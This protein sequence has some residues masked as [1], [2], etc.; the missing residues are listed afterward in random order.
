MSNPIIYR[1]EVALRDVLAERERQD[2]KW[3]E[4]NHDFG[5]FLA[6]LQEEVGEAS[7][8][9]LKSR[10]PSDRDVS[11]EEHLVRLREEL[12][13]VAAVALQMVEAFDRGACR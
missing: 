7:R 4:Q 3:G 9:W 5:T 8:D 12:V 13:Q 11:R 1:H 6:I 10:T 2:A